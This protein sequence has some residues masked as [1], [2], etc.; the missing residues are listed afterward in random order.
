[1]GFADF[2]IRLGLRTSEFTAGKNKAVADLNDFSLKI[3]GFIGKA[4]KMGDA[5][6]AGVSGF[7]VG[8]LFLKVNQE[9]D[10]LIKKAKEI[11]IGST[12]T[13]LDS[14]RFQQISNVAE[15]KGSS[16]DSF[17]RSEEKVADAMT[18]IRDGDDQGAKLQ[19]AMARLGVTMDDIKKK[20]HQ[21][22]WFEIAENMKH[23]E[24]TTERL[25]ALKDIFGKNAVELIPVFREGL[26][27]KIA[28]RGVLDEKEIK[29]L[30]DLAKLSKEAAQP[31]KDVGREVVIGFGKIKTGL[32]GFLPL[33]TGFFSGSEDGRGAAVEKN[34]SQRLVESRARKAEAEAAKAAEKAKKD[35][36]E[37]RAKEIAKRIEQEQ[38]RAQ[39]EE[40]ASARPSQRHGI[41]SGRNRRLATELSN[42]DADI[43]ING[44]PTGEKA[45]RRLELQ[46][47]LSENRR[48]ITDA[49]RNIK[50]VSLLTEGASDRQR[51]GLFTGRNENRDRIFQQQLDAQRTQVQR[52][53][54]V[55]TELR[56]LQNIIED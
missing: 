25:A 16:A 48:G 6:K 49:N 35:E 54:Q 53:E 34:L 19:R 10:D 15:A 3:D 29:D 52:L 7:A 45:L 23:V 43:R 4:M 12:R 5:L 47:Q 33:V 17:M 55:V 28:N 38:D 39:R 32:I 51:I 56:E 18:S 2:I 46:N 24:M 22:V 40:V 26:D 20:N 44:D 1:M 50:G 11:K 31:W 36:L 30:T 13:G 42:I 8:K 9:L 27:G 37:K 41:L 21:Q 14:T